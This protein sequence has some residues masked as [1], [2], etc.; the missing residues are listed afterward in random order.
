M[1]TCFELNVFLCI[2]HS[3]LHLQCLLFTCV[4]GI[5]MREILRHKTFPALPGGQKR[6][7][8]PCR[9]QSK[10]PPCTSELLPHPTGP[11]GICSPKLTQ[12]SQWHLC[13]GQGSDSAS[14]RRGFSPKLQRFTGQKN[15]S[16]EQP[17]KKS[18]MQKSLLQ[19][20]GSSPDSSQNLI[21]ESISYLI[22]KRPPNLSLDSI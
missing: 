6:R 11:G 21:L 2:N 22:N 19:F 7:P 17:R 9:L 18:N 14:W 20:A 10:T 16:P 3:T 5:A 4:K 13:S 15:L 1:V 8:L 12:R